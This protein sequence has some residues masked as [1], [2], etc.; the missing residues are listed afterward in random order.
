[1]TLT[2]RSRQDHHQFG[3]PVEGGLIPGTGGQGVPAKGAAGIGR[4]HETRF[5]KLRQVELRQRV[6]APGCE[7]QPVGGLFL[8]LV[9]AFAGQQH[10]GEVC[11]RGDEAIFRRL[12]VKK[13]GARCVLLDAEAAPQ[14]VR[15]VALGGEVAILRQR[16]PQ[17]EGPPIAFRVIGL[18]PVREL[19][20]QHRIARPRA[21]AFLCCGGQGGCKGR[22][23]TETESNEGKKRRGE[24]HGHKALWQHGAGGGTARGTGQLART[25]CAAMARARA[26]PICHDNKYAVAARFVQPHAFIGTIS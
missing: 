16:Q 15:H 18:H 21:V 20:F 14:H 7:I 9:A 10:H 12:P 4:F 2:A 5:V 11:L 23:E 6:A 17:L 3:Q 13:A 24:R 22:R 25:L 8:V 1:M 26:N 19:L